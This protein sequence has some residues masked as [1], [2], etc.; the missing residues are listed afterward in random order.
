MTVLK[1]T[2]LYT[3]RGQVLY[4]NFISVFN[5]S[6]V[7]KQ[8]IQLENDKRPEE[9]RQRREDT[10]GMKPM[11]IF[12][13]ISHQGHAIDNHNEIPLHTYQNN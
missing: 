1:T 13:I 10:D 9:T 7:K 4:V 8:T 3:W 11:K 6:T 12:N 5:N 2:N